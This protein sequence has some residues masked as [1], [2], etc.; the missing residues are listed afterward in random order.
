[1]VISNWPSVLDVSQHRIQEAL[2]VNSPEASAGYL[3]QSSRPKNVLLFV[4]VLS[5]ARQRARRDAIRET[6]FTECKR[7]SHEV[8]CR[9]FTDHAGLDNET[10]NAV[11]K[12]NEEHTDLVFLS[13]EGKNNSKMTLLRSKYLRDFGTNLTAFQLCRR[14]KEKKI[15]SVLF[16]LEFT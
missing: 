11:L 6:W 12:E 16:Y 8:Y 1:M 14:L 10:S 2:Y 4:A 15:C 13:V 5:H 9:F 3:F 7:R